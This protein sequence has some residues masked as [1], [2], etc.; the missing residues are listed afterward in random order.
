M[1]QVVF[2]STVQLSDSGRE[3][4]YVNV[5]KICQRLLALER[6]SL[7]ESEGGLQGK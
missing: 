5:M 7:Q 1:P 4:E 2:E 3:G 6:L